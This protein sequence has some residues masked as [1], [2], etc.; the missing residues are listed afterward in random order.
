LEFR[1]GYG[2][3]NAAGRFLPGETDPALAGPLENR[4]R[5]SFETRV[6]PME[7]FGDSRTIG[8]LL[9]NGALE[10]WDKIGD[11]ETYQTRRQDYRG[12]FSNV[13]TNHQWITC[14]ELF[15]RHKNC[16]SAVIAFWVGLPH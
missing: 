15:W 11:T 12:E 16:R 2:S 6:L 3:A 7:D 13:G 8:L 10:T 4:W 1:I 5:H 14:Y 9:W